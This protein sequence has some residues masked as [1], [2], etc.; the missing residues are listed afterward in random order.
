[1]RAIKDTVERAFEAYLEEA[2]GLNLENDQIRRSR[3]SID[4]RELPCLV[5]NCT[6]VEEDPPGLACYRCEVQFA[7][8]THA[9]RTD[10]G[11]PP[12]QRNA[13]RLGVLVSM[14]EDRDAVMAAMN[15]PTVGPDTRTVSDFHLLGI[16]GL[17]QESM[18]ED[19]VL[20]DV[21]RVQIHCH[22][23]DRS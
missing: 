18:T 16:V 2:E 8:C 17:G 20:V 13:L 7:F 1:M 12:D 22:G 21:L 3:E 14:L 15:K 6:R 5:V 23:W 9:E 11:F 10:G 4:E 19:K